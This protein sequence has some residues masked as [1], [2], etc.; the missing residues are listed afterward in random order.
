MYILN[1]KEYIRDLLASGKK[2]DNVSN[3]YL[4]VLIAKYYFDKEKNPN[5]L[6]DIV[7]KKMLAFDIDNYQEYRY[8]NKIQK[9]CKDLCNC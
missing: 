1:E 6:I 9:V 3:G 7:K 4:I 5:A 8:A 2:P